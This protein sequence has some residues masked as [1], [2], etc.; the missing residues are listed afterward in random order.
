MTSF[1]TES[2]WMLVWLYTGQK[3]ESISGVGLGG[4]G[5]YELLVKNGLK[6]YS[7]KPLGYCVL[8]KMSNVT[9][10]AFCIRDC[11]E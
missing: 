7:G 10:S 11:I 3:K 5:G 1:T 6:F 4:L 2:D 8:T 9:I